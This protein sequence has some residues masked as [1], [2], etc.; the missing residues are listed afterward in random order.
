M[1]ALVVDDSRAIR[2]ILSRI[3]IRNGFTVFQAGDGLQALASLGGEASDVCLMC[4]DFNMPNMN[5]IE[6]VRAI[7]S[8]PTSRQIK[9]I[10]ITTETQLSSME[11]AFDAGV[12]EYVMK[13]FTAEMI[14]DKLSLLGVTNLENHVTSLA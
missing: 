5:G 4:V 14:V 1:K 8:M 3:L 6:L 11:E 9:V 7:R 10:M 2:G 13:P 12:N